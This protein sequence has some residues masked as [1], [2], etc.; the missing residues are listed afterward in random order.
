MKLHR[1]RDQR[2][3]L[4]KSL[5]DSLVLRESIET[6]LPKAKWLSGYSDKLVNRAKKAQKNLADRRQVIK[7]LSTLEAAHKLV[8][9]ISPKLAGRT[10]GYFRIERTF[11]RRGDG[12]QMARISFIDELKKPKPSK[13]AKDSP[14]E[15]KISKPDKPT[16]A[17]D[18]PTTAQP[19]VDTANKISQPIMPNQAPKRTGRR[20]DR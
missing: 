4:L 17:S 5:V 14:A 12:A 6:T 18:T 13:A 1:E 20:G 16:D 11:I 15:A 9:D 10:S 8:D 3:A 19:L 7:Q 2:R